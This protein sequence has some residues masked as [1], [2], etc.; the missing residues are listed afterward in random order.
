ME[1]H[2]QSVSPVGSLEDSLAIS[3]P[4]LTHGLGRVSVRENR[5]A[6]QGPLCM[7]AATYGTT[8]PQ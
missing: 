6:S 3:T 4:Q 8:G 1:S 7:S 2:R 5:G